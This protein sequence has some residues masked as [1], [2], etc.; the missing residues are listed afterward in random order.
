[1]SPGMGLFSGSC[2]FA[3]LLAKRFLSL[4]DSRSIHSCAG[5]CGHSVHPGLRRSEKS[6]RHSGPRAAVSSGR[7]ASPGMSVYGPLALPPARVAL[8]VVESSFP[9]PFAWRGLAPILCGT[10]PPAVVVAIR[11]LSFR[12]GVPAF[13]GRAVLKGRLASPGME[14]GIRR[15]VSS[16]SG[17]PSFEV[18]VDC[19]FKPSRDIVK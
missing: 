17:S 8:C 15:G 1:M 9:H 12:P 4:P 13:A 6:F 3:R 14:D 16:C 19:R 2:S 18:A 11:A 5:P 7:L 10:G